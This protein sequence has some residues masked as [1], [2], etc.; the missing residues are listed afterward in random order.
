MRDTSGA[1]CKPFHAEFWFPPVFAEERTG[2]ESEYYEV[3]KHVCE[4]CPLVEKCADEGQDESY[5]V[6]GGW[7]PRERRKGS[8]KWNTKTLQKANWDLIPGPSPKGESQIPVD[9][10]E[11][12]ASLRAVTVTRKK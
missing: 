10:V 2:K 6:W 4:Q 11:V 5:G 3:A 8:M 7:T 9:A 1:A 12:R